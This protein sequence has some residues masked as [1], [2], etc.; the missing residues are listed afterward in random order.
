MTGSSACDA[1]RHGVDEVPLEEEKEPQ[2]NESSRQGAAPNATD[3]S[4]AKS[5]VLVSSKS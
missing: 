2:K 1:S 5:P 3:N 4:G